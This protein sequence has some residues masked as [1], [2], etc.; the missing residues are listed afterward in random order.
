[1]QACFLL[2]PHKDFEPKGAESRIN[3]AVDF[4]KYKELLIT[5]QNKVRICSLFKFYNDRLFPNH[6]NA[7]GNDDDG[8]DGV[9]EDLDDFEKVMQDL[10]E[11][12]GDGEEQNEDGDWL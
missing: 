12:D 8:E 3:Y 1:M 5:H 7:G 10:D 6:R 11:D 4:T 9:D 2:S